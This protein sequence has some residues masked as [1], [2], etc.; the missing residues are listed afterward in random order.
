VKKKKRERERLPDSFSQGVG[1]ESQK[2]KQT[3]KQKNCT[4]SYSRGRDQEDLSRKPAVGKQC[5]DPI[6][7]KPITGKELVEW[8]KG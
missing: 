3:N 1:G 2:G 6:S 7:K 8:L 5:G 4:P